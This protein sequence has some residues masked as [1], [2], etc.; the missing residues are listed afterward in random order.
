MPF[1]SRAQ[2]GYLNAHPEILGPAALEEWNKAS[3]GLKLPK[4][5]P[6]KLKSFRAKRSKPRVPRGR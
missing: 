5:A 4:Y 3:K 1:K 6:R 2:Q